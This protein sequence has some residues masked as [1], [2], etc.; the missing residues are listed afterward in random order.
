MKI[1]YYIDPGREKNLYCLIT[2]GEKR[3]S[4]LLKYVI[5]TEKWDQEEEV[6]IDD[7]YYPTLMELKAYLS[8]R[9]YEFQRLK[10]SI[11]GVLATLKQEAEHVLTGRMQEAKLARYCKA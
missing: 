8:K 6:L 4:F 11:S 5:P 2:D 10:M 1:V 3:V 9:Y 7:P